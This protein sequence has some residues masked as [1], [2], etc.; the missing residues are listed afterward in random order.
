MVLTV[1]NEFFDTC[2]CNF[3]VDVDRN[4]SLG[5][6]INEHFTGLDKNFRY[7]VFHDG[8]YYVVNPKIKISVLEQLAGSV[9]QVSLKALPSDNDFIY[10]EDGD[11]LEFKPG[12]PTKIDYDWRK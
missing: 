2:Y 1:C 4:G 3:V 6:E 10:D 8:K 7:Q 5:S 12:V 9:I 11:A